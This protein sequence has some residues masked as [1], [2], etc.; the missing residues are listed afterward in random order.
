MKEYLLKLMHFWLLLLIATIAFELE[1]KKTLA[2][3]S[4]V[5]LVMVTVLVSIEGSVHCG[6]SEIK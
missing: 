5:E 6:F 1:L 2:A 3:S 4:G